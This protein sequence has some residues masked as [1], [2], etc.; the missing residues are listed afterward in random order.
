MFSRKMKTLPALLASLALTGCSLAG[1]GEAAPAGD[2]A[3]FTAAVFW[4]DYSD[5]F[6]ASVRA[7][8]AGD[9]YDAGI[10]FKEHDAEYSQSAQ[11]AQI[12]EALLGGA[13]ILLVNLVNS[14]AT[15]TADEICLLAEH[16]G[17]PVVFF[18]RSI[19][20][21]GDEGVLLDHYDNIV[22]VGTDPEKP[23][24]LQGEMIGEYLIEHYRE[25]DLNGDGVISYAL[26]KGEAGNTEAVLRTEY[27]VTDANRLL[28]DAGFPELAYFDPSSVDHFQLDLTGRW[29]AAAAQSYMQTNLSA[30]NPDNGNMIELII[31]NNDDMADGA[32]RALNEYGMN[33]GTEDCLT[34]PVFGVDATFTG[35][36]LVREGRMTGTIVQDADGMAAVIARIVENARHKK[37][38]LTGLDEY[39]R[40]E[41][42][43]FSNRIYL[44]SEVYVPGD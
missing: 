11:S 9:L 3:D 33:L 37:E 36:Q 20:A 8:L 17:V 18:N 40:D 39:P 27:A 6:I 32:I 21:E 12:R 24:H 42:H 35:R 28:L 38:L 29:S 1:S 26:F 16:A 34:I 15:S 10:S 5:P 14:G 23:G 19:E 43:G 25:T 22:F 31:A 4:Y 7:G 41:E 44:P 13:D 2:G 30:F